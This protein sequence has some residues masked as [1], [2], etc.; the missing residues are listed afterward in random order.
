MR[1]LGAWIGRTRR[2]C[3]RLACQ[4]CQRAREPESQRAGEATA[5]PR[6]ASPSRSGTIFVRGTGNLRVVAISVMLLYCT[7]HCGPLVD[8]TRHHFGAVGVVWAS[9]GYMGMG[10]AVRK[11]L[12][13]CVGGLGRGSMSVSGS[14][15]RRMYVSIYT[16]LYDNDV[17]MRGAGRGARRGVPRPHAAGCFYGVC[18]SQAS[19][20]RSLTRACRPVASSTR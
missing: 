18:R 3:R 10:T 19:V 13:S 8:V 12:R 9:E 16:V 4:P 7:R 6:T 2:I 5:V 1:T 14:P 20:I 17:K 11:R 15:Q